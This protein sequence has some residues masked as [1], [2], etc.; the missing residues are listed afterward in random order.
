M[1]I[2][3]LVQLAHHRW[4]LRVL[5]ELHRYSG[6][7]FVTLAQALG[8]SRSALSASLQA[9]IQMG[10]VEKNPGYGHPM[11]PEYVLTPTGLATGAACDRLCRALA[12]ENGESL[13]FKKWSLPVVAAI[14]R[15]H[16]RFADLRSALGPVTPRALALGLK[17]LEKA[18]WVKRS[19]SDAYP[20]VPHYLLNA[21]GQRIASALPH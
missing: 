6:A 4:N 9:L 18:R 15:Q 5:A 8:C 12:N 11:R 2:D 19:V 20:P 13:G 10:L 3:F 14:D 17:D 1:N 21:P 7:K 16:H